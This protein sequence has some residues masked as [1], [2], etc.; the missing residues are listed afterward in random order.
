[1]GLM[2]KK[3][4]KSFVIISI[5]TFVACYYFLGWNEY[6]SFARLKAEQARLMDFKNNNFTLTAT[7]Y[8]AAYVLIA[9]LSLPGAALMTLLGGALFG[10]FT[11]TLLVSFASTLGATLAFLVVRF[12][13]K[14]SI[15]S[16][17]AAKLKTINE[18]VKKQGAF[19]L[20]T[21]R[22]IPVFPFFLINM[23]MGLTSMKAFTF[24]WVSQLG[25]L[26]GT[27]VFVNAGT[28]LSNLE[29]LSGILSPKLIFSFVLLGVFPWIAKWIVDYF[30]AKKVYKKFKGQKP[31]KFDFNIVAIGAGAGGL[32]TSYIASAVKAKVLLVEKNKM[33]G[34][35]LNYGCVPS[36]AIIRSAK[37]LSYLS[38]AKEFGFKSASVDFDFAD[39][40]D[41]V[42]NVIKKIEPHDSVERY[43][44]LGV[45]CVMGNAK[46][47]NPWQVKIDDK[48]YNT[49]NIVIASGAEPLVPPIPGLDKIDYLTT[50]TLW[51][52]RDL[53]KRFLILGGGPIGCELAQSF[54]RLGAQVTLVE[55]APSLLGREDPDCAKFVIDRFAAEG[56]DV[57]TAHKAVA[58]EN[59]DG[60]KLIICEH[61]QEKVEIE[62]DQVLVA[63]GRRA[64]T[65][66]FGLEELDLEMSQRGTLACDEY[67]RTSVP[68]IYACGD[69]V[70]PYQFTHV[71]AHQAWYASVN[72]LFSPLKKFK[73][74]YRV[75]PWATYTDPE[76]ARVGLNEQDAKRDGV[77]YEV[78]TYGIDDLDRAIADSEDHG[79]VKV[80]TPPGSDQILGVTIVGAHG[81]DLI[82]EFVLAMKYKL[83]LNKILGTIHSYPT[84]AE[85]NKYVASQWKQKNAPQKVL[86]WL[87]KFHG[88][89]RS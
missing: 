87:K 5:L 82:A 24:F 49:K 55:M 83:G 76:I 10:L 66:G 40:M 32:V 37:M 52:I 7:I 19:Y 51:Q 69:V 79:L 89:R 21:L 28:Q 8:F 6:F 14:D 11:G 33:G 70:G 39:I 80:L 35:C 71:A 57:R 86:E 84:M 13:L 68:N 50:D 34:D 1:M 25:M 17:F 29:S 58:F 75:I 78:T 44:K 53:P 4:L 63:L 42:H 20:F 73:V 67:L 60:R 18:G 54:Q 48:V 9:A 72:A 64:R 26:A 12:L 3:L 46:I 74:D 22:L 65:K 30:R 85:A 23:L 56:V 77:E 41:R 61:G 62:F 81:G 36:K 31:K 2:S 16:K 47:L 38:R 88:W 45:D 27:A 15:Q 43:T 59:R